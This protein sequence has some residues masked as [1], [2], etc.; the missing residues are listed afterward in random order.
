MRVKKCLGLGFGLIT[1]LG[2]STT[3]LSSGIDTAIKDGTVNGNIRAYYN[4][5][6]FETKTNETAFSFGGALRAETG[7]LGMFKFGVGYYT[8]QDLDTND[9]DLAKVNKRLGSQV[10]VLGEAYVTASFTDTDASIGR[11]KLN[12]P[13]ANGGDAFVIPFTFE[14]GSLINKSV[15]NLTIQ[16]NHINSIKN[17]NSDEFVDV[18]AWST[19]RYGV[20]VTSTSGTTMLGAIHSADGIKLQAWAYNYADLFTSLYFQGNYS[21]AAMGEIKPFMAAQLVSQSGTGDELLGNV[22]STLFGL[23]GGAGFGKSK[24]TFAYTTVAEETGAFKNGAFL[25]PYSFSTSPIFTNNMLVTMENVD[26]G[27]AIK[28][29]YNYSF[30]KVKLKVSYAE[31]DFET[32]DDREA[33]DVDVTYSLNEMVKGLSARYRLESVTSDTD[34]V[35]QINNRFQLQ[36]KY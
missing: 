13:F 1:T 29:T 14:G 5:R 9:S 26:A 16:F 10:E 20:G 7:S 23:Q 22:D 27:D 15:E 30:T 36:L 25:T 19:N 3:A 21:F 18:G 12:T 8:A 31:F 17:R 4:T 28:L 24:L 35:E 33:L 11:I 32:A 2:F 34:S 6:D